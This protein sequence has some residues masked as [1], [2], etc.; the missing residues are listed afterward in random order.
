MIIHNSIVDGILLV[1]TNGIIVSADSA[2]EQIFDYSNGGLNGKYVCSI[3]PDMDNVSEPCGILKKAV[4]S[5]IGTK[6][7]K[8]GHFNAKGIHQDNSVFPVKIYVSEIN[9]EKQKIFSCFVY[10]YSQYDYAEKMEEIEN[11][12]LHSVLLGTRIYDFTHFICEKIRVLFDARLVWVGTKEKKGHINICAASGVDAESIA[13]MEMC[14]DEP[15]GEASSIAKTVQKDMVCTNDIDTPDGKYVELLFPLSVQNKVIGIFKICSTAQKI[16]NARR[17]LETFSKRLGT[18]IQVSRDQKKLQLQ[19]AAMTSSANS[20]IITDSNGVIEWVNKAFSH[21]SGYDEECVVG[22]TPSIV[23]SGVQSESDYKNL[24]S[25]ISSGNIWKGEIINRHKNGSLYT[26]SMT[27]T[28]IKDNGK[29]THFVAVQEDLTAYRNAE[30]HILHLSNYDQ[31]T[32]LPNRVLFINRLKHVIERAKRRHETVGLLFVDLINF[33]RINDTLG[34]NIGDKLLKIIANRISSLVSTEDIVARTG[35]DEFAIIYRSIRKAEN[36]AILA[37]K[38]ISSILETVR[39]DG[40]DVNVGAYIGISIFPDDCDN[41]E[42]LISFADMALHKAIEKSHNSFFFFSKE[43]DT[44]IED[45]LV[46]ERDLRRA[47]ENNEFVLHYQP[48]LDLHS[49]TLIGWEALIR[50]IHPERGMIPPDRFIPIAEDTGLIISLGEWVIKT[51]LEQWVEWKKIGL[52]DTVI[53]VNLS[54][55]QFQK[56]D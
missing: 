9:A 17:I 1:D 29:I 5:K 21:L 45:K 18:A 31:L 35:G 44:E 26:V 13:S 50:W 55:V 38:L 37:R 25:I 4:N 32:G 39:I 51:A 12:M 40:N 47:L 42:K 27:I 34:H 43:M 20:I 14:W 28:P 2:V 3:L 10:D 7:L 23:K 33:N 16:K 15:L 52:P 56:A 19:G 48:Q 22:R 46:I 6:E 49:G 24:W 53:A 11:I 41:P 8:V 36:A 30:D 54:A